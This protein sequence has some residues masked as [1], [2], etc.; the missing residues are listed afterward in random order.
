MLGNYLFFAGSR[1]VES[2][3]IEKV[4]V[5]NVPHLRIKT[6]EKTFSVL[7]E[8][9][10]IYSSTDRQLISN[11]VRGKIDITNQLSW[12]YG[13][14]VLRSVL[15]DYYIRHNYLGR[16]IEDIKD[17]EK[18]LADIPFEKR[19]EEFGERAA[20]LT[21][22]L[23]HSLPDSAS[24]HSLP[25]FGLLCDLCSEAWIFQPDEG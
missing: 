15:N 4:D 24:I 2:F 22:R 1:F 5:N 14:T 23:W 11:M 7:P 12:W 19:S 10:L 25:R 17:F 6:S 8:A 20:H 3:G 21:E 18:S 16:A 9:D 13:W